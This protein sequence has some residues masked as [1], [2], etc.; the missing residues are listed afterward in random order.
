VVGVDG[1]RLV[2][3]LLAR[4][5]E[6]EGVARAEPASPPPG[7]PAQSASPTL[8]LDFEPGSRGARALAAAS[9]VGAGANRGVEAL[10]ADLA[11]RLGQPLTASA[12]GPSELLVTVDLGRA[13]AELA[14]R[15]NALADDDYAEVDQLLEPLP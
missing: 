11:E 3:R 13:T 8:R 10:T 7:S 15:L 2:E 5:R 6:L 12:V 1:P 4:C 9:G 14:R